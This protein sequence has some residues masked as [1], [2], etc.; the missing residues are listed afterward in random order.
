MLIPL[1]AYTLFLQPAP[2]TTAEARAHIGEQA[3]VCGLVRSA[4]WASNSNRR[5]TFLNLDAAYP[6]QLFTVVIFEENRG[7]FTPAPETQ[8]D[9]KRIC[10]TG[11][12]ED[13]RGTPEIVVSMPVQIVETPAK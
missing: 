9:R 5:P 3:T 10:V 4:R 7:K 2:L 6:K 1:L 12:I 11:K 8:F 13:F